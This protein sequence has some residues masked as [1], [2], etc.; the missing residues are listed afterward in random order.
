MKEFLL[1]DKK[2]FVPEVVGWNE[3]HV[4][5]VNAKGPNVHAEHHLCSAQIDAT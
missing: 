4:K 2:L 3:I 5:C 1:E